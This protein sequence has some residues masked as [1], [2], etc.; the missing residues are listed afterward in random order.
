[1]LVDSNLSFPH[2]GYAIGRQV[3]GAVRRNRLR[4]RLQ[5]IMSTHDTDLAPGWYL[6]GV[7]VAAGSY[8]YTQLKDNLERLLRVIRVH[9]SGKTV[10]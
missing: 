5:A 9:S 2:V 1:M 7:S 6:I 3:G 8:G 4:R 10:Q